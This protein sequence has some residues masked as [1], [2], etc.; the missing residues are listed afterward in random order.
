MF[1]V[2]ALL[3]IAV[4]L[5]TYLAVKTESR[6]LTDGLILMGKHLTKDIATNTENAFWSLNW[7]FVEEV[8]NESFQDNRY[9]VIYAKIIK[10]DGEVYMANNKAYY[11][12]RVDMSLLV[13]QETLVENYFFQE[14]EEYGYLLMQP[15]NIGKERWHIILGLTKNQSMQPSMI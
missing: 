11:G 5:S 6:V 3:V 8:L 15:V 2:V 9:G 14:T 12:T 7:I 10:P 1:N 4:G 13:D